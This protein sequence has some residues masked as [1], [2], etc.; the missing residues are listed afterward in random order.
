MNKNFHDSKAKFLLCKIKQNLHI[1]SLNF[2]RGLNQLAKSSFI[3]VQLQRYFVV[4][5]Q[6]SFKNIYVGAICIL[7][8]S[9]YLND[10]DV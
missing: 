1:E 6:I 7:P 9:L 4:K 3:K 8:E 2:N 10:L 5:M